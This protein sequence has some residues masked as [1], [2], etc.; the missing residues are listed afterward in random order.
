MA[1]RRFGVSFRARAL[2]PLSPPSR[3]SATAAGFFFVFAMRNKSHK[4]DAVGSR[5]SV[6]GRSQC[7]PHQPPCHATGVRRLTLNPEH[8]LGVPVKQLAL[9]LLTRRQAADGGNHL[10]AAALRA[11]AIQ[12]V[13]VAPEYQLVLVTLDEL[14][15]IVFVAG[16]RGGTPRA[17][18]PPL[19]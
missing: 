6:T 14:T 1:L 10:R 19:Q 11:V 9:D 18:H 15:G 13:A 16:G 3:P 8:P 4:P 7:L 12:I 17:A 5:N 2:P